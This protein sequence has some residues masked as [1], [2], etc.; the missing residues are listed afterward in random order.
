M[1]RH[2]SDLGVLVAAYILL[3]VGSFKL[4]IS[5]FQVTCLDPRAVLWLKHPVLRIGTTRA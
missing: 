2:V 1:I 3:T 4:V 5:H